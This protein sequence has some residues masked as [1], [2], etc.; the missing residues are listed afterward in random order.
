MAG[1]TGMAFPPFALR[2][3]VSPCHA[4]PSVISGRSTA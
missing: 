1:L 2:C 3:A 4:V